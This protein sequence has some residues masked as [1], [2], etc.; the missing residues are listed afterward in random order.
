[1]EIDI[2][3]DAV[4]LTFPELSGFEASDN[5]V[6]ENLGTKTSFFSIES[7]RL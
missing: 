7:V 6:S 4:Q 1:M 2:A 5:M 3:S